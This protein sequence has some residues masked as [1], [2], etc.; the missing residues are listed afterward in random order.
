MDQTTIAAAQ[1]EQASVEQTEEYIFEQRMRYLDELLDKLKAKFA[2]SHADDRAFDRYL[3]QNHRSV[4]LCD[5]CR[6]EV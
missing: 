2:E 5:H 4:V 6:K 1:N 3:A